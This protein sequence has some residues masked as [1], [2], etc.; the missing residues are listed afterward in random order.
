VLGQIRGKPLVELDW[1]PHGASA[2]PPAVSPPK[3][4]SPIPDSMAP[5]TRR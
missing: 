4:T 1:L 5:P 3:P 2:L